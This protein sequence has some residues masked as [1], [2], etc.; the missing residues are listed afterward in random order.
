VKVVLRFTKA[1]LAPYLP[2]YVGGALAL[3][4][5]NGM[6][7][8]IPVYLAQAID[9]LGSPDAL[10]V[11]VVNAAWIAAL[12]V[13]IIG[14]RTL[15]RVLFFTPGRL[16]EARVKRDLFAR[17]LEQ[18]PIFLR[19]YPAGDLYSRVSSDVN[20]LRL[21]A[22]FGLLSLINVVTVLTLTTAQ[23]VALSPTL[24][25]YL[26]IPLAIGLGLTQVTI[27]WLFVLIKRMNEEISQISD[28]AL[29]SYEGIATLK[30]FAT[31]RAFGERFDAL[32]A[33]YL[34]SSVQRAGLRALIGPILTTA[35]LVDVFLLLWIGGAY[36]ISGDLS[37]GE[38]VA[39]VSL[40][41][42]LTAPLRG[43]SFI[44]AIVKQAQASLDRFYEVMEP[45]VERPDRPEPQPAPTSPPSIVVRELTFSY[46]GAERPALRDVSFE[47]PAGATLGVFGATGAGKST[48]LRCLTRLYNPAPGAI[49][50]DGVDVRAIDLDAWRAAAVLVPQRAFL[51]SESVRDNVLLGADDGGRLQTVIRR[52]ALQQD[53]DALPAGLQTQVGEAGLM[54]SGGQRQRAALARGLIREPC[55]LILDD[56]L[57]AVDH[58]TEAE[59]LASLRGRG[60]QPPTT[61]IVANRISAIQHA[62]VI[63][64]LDAGA[65]VDRGTHADLVS[66]PGI[67]RET[68][69]KQREGED[70]A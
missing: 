66:R 59:L 22:G 68:W 26:L 44:I 18:Q 5:T 4:A 58:A 35:A 29:S 50:I 40:V 45:P 2:W 36:V 48:L 64:V 19:D 9:A 16:V 41:A 42:I 30:A 43:L 62:E 1:Y 55:V 67:Y 10:D 12:G 69:E 27:R 23:M 28:Y 38:L 61:V 24:T 51:F 56:V 33:A 17:I 7:V 14:V 39:L 32:N 31:E 20:A 15:S 46:P 34:H 65:V 53:I 21:L 52:T 25:V 60:G 8:V 3:V 6:A 11:V 47:L 37:A 63:L 54:L 49:L 57:S 70:A 13:A